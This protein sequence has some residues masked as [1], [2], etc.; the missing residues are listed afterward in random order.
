MGPGNFIAGL[1]V[2]AP[3]LV[4]RFVIAFLKAAVRREQ[5]NQKRESL[6]TS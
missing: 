5:A 3:R 2:F 1:R 4:D 6:S